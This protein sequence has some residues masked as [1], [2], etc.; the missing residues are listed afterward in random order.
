VWRRYFEWLGEAALSGM[1]DIL[2]HP[3]L[4]KVWGPERP[5][6]E[7]DPRY[8]YELA[9]EG[10]AESGIAVEVSTAGLRKPVGEL[11]PSTAFLEMVLD[12]GNPIALSSDA[13]VPGDLGSGYEQALE[14]L[15]ALGVREVCVFERRGRRLEPLGA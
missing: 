10:I 9:M 13:H 3:D 2:A 11:Y 1:F 7:R 8:F 15:D 4:V 6:P 5:S 12:A 14:V